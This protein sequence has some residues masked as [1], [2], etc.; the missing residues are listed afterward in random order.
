M[1]RELAVA[2][3]G[4]APVLIALRED[5]GMAIEF[6]IQADIPSHK[7]PGFI[8]KAVRAA[9][10]K[11]KLVKMDIDQHPEIPGQMGIQSIPAVIAFDKGQPVDQPRI[12]GFELVAQAA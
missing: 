1:L 8:E 2:G 11:V 6:V 9:K 3:V 10:G 4:L 5:E 7:I 12:R